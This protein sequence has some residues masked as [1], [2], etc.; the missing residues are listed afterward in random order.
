M[1]SYFNPAPPDNHSIPPSIQAILTSLSS[2]SASLSKTNPTTSLAERLL[3]EFRATKRVN[4]EETNALALECIHEILESILPDGELRGQRY[5]AL[6]PTRNDVN[7]GSFGIDIEKGIWADFATED[8]GGDVVSFVK[9]VNNLDSQPE[10]AV[11]ILEFIAGIE[12]LAQKNRIETNSKLIKKKKTHSEYTHI[13]PIPEDAKERPKF[14]GKDL[15]TPSDIWEYKNAEGKTLFYVNRFETVSGKE[16]RPL[17]YCID[18]TGHKSWQLLA[19]ASPRPAYGL[20]RLAARPGAPVLFVEGEKAADAAQRLFL[21]FVAVTTMNGAKSPEKTDFSPF[22][23]REI[24]FAPDNDEAGDFYQN[25]VSALLKD[26]GAKVIATISKN[27]FQKND[28]PLA[29]GYD[30]ADA[31]ADGWTQADITRIG[32]GLWMPF[33]MADEATINPEG[34]HQQ[35]SETQVKRINNMP[36]GIAAFTAKHYPNGLIFINGEFYAYEN[37]Y[38]PRLDIQNDIRRKMAEFLGITAHP[39]VINENLI[40][41]KDFFSEREQTAQPDR[42]LICMRNGTYNTTNFS[43]EAHSPTHLLRTK[44]NVDW[45]A[46]SQ[47]PRW[48]EFVREI[49]AQDSDVDEKVCFIQEFLGY[50]LVPDNSQHKWVL[51]VGEGGNGKSVLLNIFT[52][53]IGKENISNAHIERL[54]DKHSR[55]ELENKLVNISSEMSANA[56]VSDGY[57]KQIVSGD[58]IEAERKFKDP[59]SFTPF[60]RLICATNHLPRLLDLSDG[61]FRRL[62]ILKFNR[63]FT[64]NEID[65]NLTATLT[66]EL[67]GILRW[68]LDGLQRLRQ[69]G[70]FIIPKSSLAESMIYKNESDPIQIFTEECIIRSDKRGLRPNQ[71]YP[72]YNQWCKNNGFKAHSSINFGKRMGSLKYEKSRSSGKDYWKVEP[73]DGF[74]NIWQLD[75]GGAEFVDEPPAAVIQPVAKCPAYVV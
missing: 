7:P 72:A 30:L 62:V 9:Y 54:G 63:Q 15:G 11:K 50:C 75:V 10:A 64:G 37:G 40:L 35:N 14:F 22:A 59:F 65:P 26:V 12:P 13:F 45:D 19:P 51:M 28:E 56:T 48:Q 6:N 3:A 44:V 20:D 16:F 27:H 73:L 70:A 2:T 67:P 29:K 61:F 5:V 55:A 69:R 21:D 60:V 33:T 68:A 24:Y 17:S 47:C 39:K 38:W 31:E 18:S 66:Q 74:S 32:N 52:K 58:D 25:R 34:S 49:F 23:G 42:T 41:L 36:P 71:I 46:N 1:N 43:L 8:K 53:L 57:L 4:F